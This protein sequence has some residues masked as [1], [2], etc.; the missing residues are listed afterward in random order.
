MKP[1][2]YIVY[3]LS[4]LLFLWGIFLLTEGRHGL[5]PMILGACC[6]HIG[7]PPR[8]PKPPREGSFLP[9]NRLE[10][11]SG[12]VLLAFVALL[13]F[14]FLTA[15]PPLDTGREPRQPLSPLMG[16]VAGLIMVL[17]LGAKLLHEKRNTQQ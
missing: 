2:R 7:R 16:A 11:I 4:T 5:L 12:L 6:S 1:L 17:L 10:W 13:G 9:A 14:L 8:S 3:A 15:A